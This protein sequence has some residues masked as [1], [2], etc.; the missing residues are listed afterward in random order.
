MDE[1][2]ISWPHQIQLTFLKPSLSFWEAKDTMFE[3]FVL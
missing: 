2:A 1:K 3:T